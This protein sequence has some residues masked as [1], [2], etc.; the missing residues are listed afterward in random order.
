MEVSGF[1][2]RI[3]RCHFILSGAGAPDY[4]CLEEHPMNCIE[5]GTS[6]SGPQIE[7]IQYQ[8]GLPD[9]YLENVQVWRCPK[10]HDI[11]V[12]I[13]AIESLHT[14]L[15][16]T[17]AQKQG[18]LSPIE[19]RFI[20]EAKGWSSSMAASE[21]GVALGTWSKWEHGKLLMSRSME[22]LLRLLAMTRDP[23]TEYPDMKTIDSPPGPQPSLRLTIRRVGEEW[24]PA[25]K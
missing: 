15:V 13:P 23:I 12:E 21:L 7:Q 17:V 9:V 16:R 14:A 2:E 20:R 24:E 4:L 18:R 8:C 5:C 11:E 3:H 10:C 22:R 1:H 19:I 6:M 25:A